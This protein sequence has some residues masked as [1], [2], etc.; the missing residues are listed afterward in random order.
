MLTFQN[1]RFHL[2]DPVSPPLPPPPMRTSHPLYLGQ[3][4]R[5]NGPGPLEKVNMMS[6][7]PLCFLLN[8]L[9][10]DIKAHTNA[11]KVN[12]L[13]QKLEKFFWIW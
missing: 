1:K 5:Q 10:N 13:F 3:S 2:W 12:T 9:K 8:Q 7:E 6:G 4:N 11:L